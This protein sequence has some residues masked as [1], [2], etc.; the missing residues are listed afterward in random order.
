MNMQSQVVLLDD[1]KM[2]SWIPRVN[3]DWTGAIPATLIYNRDFR[4]FYEKEM[5]FEELE[6]IITPLIQ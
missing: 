2:N 1:P 6:A 3:E 5:K 4:Q